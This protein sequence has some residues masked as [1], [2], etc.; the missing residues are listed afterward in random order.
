M[1]LKLRLALVNTVFVLLALGLGLFFLISQTRR[2]FLESIDRDL[3]NRARMISRNPGMRNNGG[4]GPGG[5]P[6]NQNQEPPGLQGGPRGMGGDQVPGQNDRPQDFNNPINDDIGRPIRYDREG[7]H[8]NQR[9]T[10][11][12]DPNGVSVKG[13]NHPIL[14]TVP[15][16]G[17]PTRVITMPI[18]DQD[19]P[20]GFIQ[21]G[22]DLQDFDRL[23]QTQTITIL[24]LLPF[25]VIIAGLVGWF[26]AGRAVKPINDVA[27]ASEK[28]SGSDMSTRLAVSSDDEIGRLCTAFNGMV[29]RLQ[30]SFNERQKLLD[31]L[32]V[33]LE[34]QRQFV[35]DASHELRTP[36]ARIR[37]TTSSALEQESSPAEMKE[38]LEIAD[39]ETVHM[40]NLVDQLLTLARLDS[41]HA[42]TLGEVNLAEIAKEAASKFPPQIENPMTF[43]LEPK[44]VIRGDTEGL[45]RA[46]VNLLENAKRYSPDKPI[47]V[48][49]R[50]SEG[51]CILSIRDHG[52]GIEPQHL[53]R[54]T[55]RFYRVDD[56]RNRKMGGTG[57]GLAIVK[58]IVESSGGKLHIES[59]PSAGTLVELIFP[60]IRE[61]EIPK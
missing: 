20:I 35:G 54:L 50:I 44:A 33:A 2:V 32:K 40:S 23:K 7:K 59:K 30:L 52:I 21:F 1:S 41:G 46:V 51:S 24:W 34:K 61:I 25:S 10:R 58:S 45:V 60:K 14:A 39:R 43:D 3:A 12:L 9:E 37:I 53:S 16:E 5:G 6:F 4:G 55:E 18:L 48:T 47:V 19:Q 15:V 26:L 31:D 22:H 38:A 36:L 11:V 17:I 49:T 8:L 57:L 42:P 56:A 29:D 27:V 28:I 13:L